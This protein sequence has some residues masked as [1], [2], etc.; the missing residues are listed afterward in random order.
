MQITLYNI[1][2]TLKEPLQLLKS[3]YG[4]T[5]FGKLFYNELT[6][7]LLEAYFIQ[8]QCKMYIYDKYEPDGS[9]FFVLSYFDDCVYWYTNE[10]LGKW[11]F[12]NSGKRFHVNFLEYAHCSCQ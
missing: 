8:S 3:I 10:Y 9:I 2:M 5:N 12:D 11:F 7:W 4:V 6:E 1:Q